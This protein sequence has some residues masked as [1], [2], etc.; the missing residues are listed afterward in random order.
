[1]LPL[2]PPG[3]AGAA[4]ALTAGDLREDLYPYLNSQDSADLE[5]WTDAELL[6]W[7]NQG[8]ERLARKAA[9]FVERNTSVAVVN[10]TAV[11]SLP[12][13][14]LATIHASL[15][16][17][18]LRASSRA[19][20]DARDNGWKTAEGDVTHYLHDHGA[21]LGSIR[22]YKEPQA[23]GTLAL[24]RTFTPAALAASGAVALPDILADHA[25]VHALGEAR[26]REG[27]AAMPETAAVCEELR[28]IYERVAREYWGVPT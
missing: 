2:I 14:H 5:H 27:D 9:V 24:I 1:M 13:R 15:G 12:A 26:R 22:L 8:F 7:L 4:P 17:S 6:L 11:Y 18:P 23:N 21:G 16:G 10:G 20:L 3:G 19:E 25:F 28:S